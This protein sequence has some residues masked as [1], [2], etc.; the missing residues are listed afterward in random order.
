MIPFSFVIQR[1]RQKK[2]Y[3]ICRFQSTTVRAQL[4]R[5]DDCIRPPLSL[6]A[7]NF[8]KDSQFILACN[9]DAGSEKWTVILGT[10]IEDK[11]CKYLD[12]YGKGT[13][14]T[15]EDAYKDLVKQSALELDNRGYT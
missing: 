9:V 15:P 5:H 14:G 10:P 7:S 2:T 1:R 11:R 3:V 13:G 4:A 12:A 8:P 6:L